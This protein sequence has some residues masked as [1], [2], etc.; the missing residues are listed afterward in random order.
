[1]TKV[2]IPQHIAQ[3]RQFEFVTGNLKE[4]AAIDTNGRVWT[5]GATEYTLGRPAPSALDKRTLTPVTAQPERMVKVQTFYGGIMALGESGRLWALGKNFYNIMAKSELYLNEVFEQ[6]TAVVPHKRF[7]DFSAS[8]HNLYGIDDKGDIWGWGCD[9]SYALGKN[10]GYKAK[11]NA[12]FGDTMISDGVIPFK[13]VIAGMHKMIALREDG[14]LGAIGEVVSKLVSDD[15][16]NVTYKE[17]KINDS[18]DFV[19]K[20]IWLNETIFY[21]IKEDDT[22]WINGG[23]NSHL[24]GLNKVNRN[25]KLTKL[26]NKR[27]DQLAPRAGGMYGLQKDGSLWTWGS[28]TNA[29]NFIGDAP[30]AYYYSPSKVDITGITKLKDNMREV[31][32]D[33]FEYFY[34]EQKIDLT[35]RNQGLGLLPVHTTSANVLDVRY[36][37]KEFSNTEQYRFLKF[38]GTAFQQVYMTPEEGFEQGHTLEYIKTNEAKILELIHARKSKRL[39]FVAFSLL[40]GETDDYFLKEVRQQID[41]VNVNDGMRFN[42]RI[43]FPGHSKNVVNKELVEFES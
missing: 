17:F 2:D 6:F 8:H 18:D 20:D 22:L 33:E 26:G 10:P 43:F 42:S 5:C 41:E 9:T 1:M 12:V 3:G 24:E 30:S 34:D 4:T 19:F 37:F 39:Y 36:L 14:R 40:K 29:L 7:I 27:W 13:K 31:E 35:L 38:N 32:V 15:K 25:G 23:S 11:N 28:S 16:N 21:G